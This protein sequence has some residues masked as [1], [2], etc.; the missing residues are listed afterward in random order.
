[1]ELYEKIMI[2]FA[3]AYVVAIFMLSFEDKLDF[4]DYL[5]IIFAPISLPLMFIWAIFNAD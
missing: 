4:K 1:M 5:V 2:Y 3:I